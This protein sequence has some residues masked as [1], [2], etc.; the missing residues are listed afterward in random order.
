MSTDKFQAAFHGSVE[1]MD[2]GELAA[3]CYEFIAPYVMELVV[4]DSLS[5]EIVASIRGLVRR[6]DR[7]E[8]GLACLPES[9][10]DDIEEG[11]ERDYYDL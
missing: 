7:I 1:S 2:E 11:D 9:I 6:G 8:V 4:R 3:K 10:G 5:A